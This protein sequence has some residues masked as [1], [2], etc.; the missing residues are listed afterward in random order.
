MSA[1]GSIRNIDIPKCAAVDNATF[2]QAVLRQ[3]AEIVRLWSTA[4]REARAGD[5]P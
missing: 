3:Q 1:R 5:R 2:G 4:L